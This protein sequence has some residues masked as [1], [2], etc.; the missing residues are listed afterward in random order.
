MTASFVL[1]VIDLAGVEE[2]VPK[3]ILGSLEKKAPAFYK[4]ANDV[5][6]QKSVTYIW[7]KEGVAERTKTRIAKQNAEAAK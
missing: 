3:S 6:K 4:W 2:L 1:R 7:D 5:T